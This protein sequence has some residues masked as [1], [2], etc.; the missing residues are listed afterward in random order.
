M[1]DYLVERN[2][3]RTRASS[4]CVAPAGR[5]PNESKMELELG[6]AVVESAVMGTAKVGILM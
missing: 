1:C 4:S 3:E 5:T 6:S 2:S